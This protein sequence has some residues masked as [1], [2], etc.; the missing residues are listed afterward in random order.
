MTRRVASKSWGERRRE[1]APER[2]DNTLIDWSKLDRLAAAEREAYLRKALEQIDDALSAPDRN[3][4][5]AKVETILMNL[6]SDEN[7]KI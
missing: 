4:R 2:D 6:G 7:L 5:L 1:D 3:H